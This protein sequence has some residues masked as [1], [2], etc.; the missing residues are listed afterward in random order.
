MKKIPLLFIFMLLLTGCE[1][2]YVS[3][4][5]DMYEMYFDKYLKDPS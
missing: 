4:G 5:R 2:R 1:N 3:E